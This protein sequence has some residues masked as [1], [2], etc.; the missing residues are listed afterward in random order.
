MFFSLI[1]TGLAKQ[2]ISPTIS[3]KTWQDVKRWIWIPE[4]AQAALSLVSYNL[5]WTVFSAAVLCQLEYVDLSVRDN[6]TIE[7][8]QQL[9]DLNDAPSK[10]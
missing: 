7:Y 8:F 1:S 9:A 6:A 2:Q 5:P 3:E 10:V 4:G